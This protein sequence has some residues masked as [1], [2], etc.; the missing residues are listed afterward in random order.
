MDKLSR[1]CLRK[2]CFYLGR[3]LF[4]VGLPFM[5]ICSTEFLGFCPF[6]TAFSRVSRGLY[7]LKRNLGSVDT[8]PPKRPLSAIPGFVLLCLHFPTKPS[9]SNSL[10]G[11]FGKGSLKKMFCRKCSAEFPQI[12][13]NF[14]THRIFAKCHKISAEFPQTFR[15]NTFTND[16]FCELLK[17]SE[18]RKKLLSVS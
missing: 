1:N 11:S 7:S 2:L 14:C 10:M 9:F 17:V 6:F 13:R 8:D 3:W 18:L 4:G 5:S 16:P 15:E 12:L